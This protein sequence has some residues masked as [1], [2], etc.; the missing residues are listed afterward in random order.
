MYYYFSFLLQNS[1]IVK[2]K[3]I[4]AIT[5]KIKVYDTDSVIDIKLWV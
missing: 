4:H 2:Y 3:Y 5:C 1:V